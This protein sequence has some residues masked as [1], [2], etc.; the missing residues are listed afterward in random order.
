MTSGYRM[1]DV[2]THVTEPADLWTSR[3]PARFRDR[4]PYI[5]TDRRGR[6]AWYL[7]GRRIASVGFTAVA[8]WTEPL[9]EGG[10]LTMEQLHPASYDASA[11]LRYMDSEGIWAMVLYPNVG[12]FGSQGFL[13][14]GDAELMLACVQ[15]YNDFQTEWASA[16]P[17]RLLPITA[18]PFWDV[19]AAVEEI[20]RG[21]E[22][23]HRGV[24]FTGEP[25]A[26]GL[27]FLGDRHWD[28]LWAAAQELGA[29][30]SLHIGS[31][32]FEK[33]FSPERIRTYGF[34][35]AYA[36]VST[37]LFMGNGAHLCDLLLSGVLARFPELQVVSVE[38]GIGW[39]PFLL[40]ALD[41]QFQEADVRRARPELDLLPSEYFARQVYACYW[42]EQIGPQR[43]IDCIGANRIMIETDFPHPT[44]LYGNVWERIDGGLAGQSEE[45]RRKI[46]WENA[47]RL[48]RVEP[49]A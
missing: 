18:T 21:H 46:L 27:P 4:V 13:K 35:A 38:S 28:P 39:V 20:R 23:G 15:A 9:S 17:R 3:A 8:G 49:P 25:E 33:D 26:F 10:P 45:V 11:R 29:P 31:G 22:L 30:I 36:R 32:D 2:D 7:E 40:E 44:C 14:L 37:N 24:L 41:H 19:P 5:D 34:Q 12:G 43:L 1:I 16:D 6:Q 47:A 48:Y 42:F